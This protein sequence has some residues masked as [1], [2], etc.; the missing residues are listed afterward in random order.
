MANHHFRW[1]GTTADDLK[2]IDANEYAAGCPT[3]QISPKRVLGNVQIGVIG[4]ESR[5][6]IVSFFR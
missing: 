1:D 3:P 5:F 6:N 4:T 2:Q